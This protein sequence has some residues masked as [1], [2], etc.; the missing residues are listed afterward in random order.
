M[1]DARTTGLLQVN[2]IRTIEKQQAVDHKF[3]NILIFLVFINIAWCV[4]AWRS[5]AESSLAAGIV[6]GEF[7]YSVQRGES[8]ASVGARFGVAVRT[9]ARAN[10]LA[11]DARLRE[12]QTLHV[13][14]RH[15]VPTTLA[16]GILINIPQRMLFYFKS[17]KLTYHF[18]V[19]LGR[20]D[21]P[22][23][24]GPFTILSTEQDPVWDVPKS[25]QE[26]MRRA[27]KPVLTCVP[28]GPNNP[29]GKHWLGLSFPGYGIHGTIAPASIYQFR[30][31]GCVR[32]HP[33]DVAELS[34]V[35]SAG[36]TGLITYRR[37]M[38]ARIGNQIYLE[39]HPD[40]Y[41]K[42]PNALTQFQDIARHQNF[43]GEVDWQRAMDIIRKQAGIARLITKGV[44]P[45]VEK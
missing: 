26:E 5:E 19:G 31:H 7:E 30:T 35:V 25:I 27:G 10:G 37:L 41:G 1:S 36:T 8:L 12:N 9:L 4:F 23:P 32:L 33:D 13:D 2:E 15:I 17:G 42:I 6:G 16:D 34:S 3:L 43:A 38:V 44:D 39:V 24:T 21:W 18:P 40:V 45:I 20:P 29:L 28:P 14:N 11:H 22:T